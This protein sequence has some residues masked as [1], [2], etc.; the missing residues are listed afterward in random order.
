MPWPKQCPKCRNHKVERT[1]RTFKCMR[2]GYFVDNQK[3]PQQ[4]EWKTYKR[5]SESD[6]KND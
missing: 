3:V 1:K 6:E 2:C 5:K 4:L